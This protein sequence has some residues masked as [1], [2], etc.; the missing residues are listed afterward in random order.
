MTPSRTNGTIPPTP[1]GTKAGQTSN[2]SIVGA[3]E[4]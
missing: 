3:A 2:L 4:Y 1:H